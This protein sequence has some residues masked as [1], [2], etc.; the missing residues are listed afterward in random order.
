M[1]CQPGPRTSR[2]RQQLLRSTSSSMRSPLLPRFVNQN[3]RVRMLQ[4]PRT[5]PHMWVPN[6]VSTIPSRSRAQSW[7]DFT[8]RCQPAIFLS[9]LSF[10]LIF[11]ALREHLAARLQPAPGP[12]ARRDLAGRA[13]KRISRQSGEAVNF[14]RERRGRWEWTGKLRAK[15][16]PCGDE[17]RFAGLIAPPWSGADRLEYFCRGRG[18]LNW[19][20][21]DYR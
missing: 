17:R 20:G 3:R 10:C 1:L 16:A 8:R 13:G 21:P 7:E 6:G 9:M 15:C 18:K 11:A 4:Q 14:V 19:G 12:R 5:E 2:R